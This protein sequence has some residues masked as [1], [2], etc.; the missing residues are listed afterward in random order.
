MVGTCSG[1]YKAF[2][3][4]GAVDNVWLLKQNK[5]IYKKV[6][7]FTSK[8]W[9]S[10]TIIALANLQTCWAPLCI[11][12]TLSAKLFVCDLQRSSAEMLACYFRLMHGA[13]NEYVLVG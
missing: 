2:G 5:Q 7:V 1:E 11:P 4:N 6:W 12:C 10:N 8:S 3:L 13:N 9:P